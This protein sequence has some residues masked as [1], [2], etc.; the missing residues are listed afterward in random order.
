MVSGLGAY[1]RDYWIACVA[2]G[3]ALRCDDH[4]MAQ[5]FSAEHRRAPAMLVDAGQRRCTDQ[6][7]MAHGFT[8]D[9]LAG[10]VRAGLATATLQRMRARP[11][12]MSCAA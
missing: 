4:L 11:R 1:A 9:L 7:I 10:L 2:A 12:F 6:L 8:F 3:R 5:R